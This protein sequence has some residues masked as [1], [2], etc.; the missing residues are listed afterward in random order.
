M[1]VCGT[2][3]ASSRST[4]LLLGGCAFPYLHD[5]GERRSVM[6][7]VVAIAIAMV[8]VSRARDRKER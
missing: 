1:A 2:H 3:I 6:V 7:V 8:M 4:L 5:G